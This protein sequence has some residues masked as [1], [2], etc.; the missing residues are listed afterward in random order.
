MST[1]R[2][3]PL[4]GLVFVD[5]ASTGNLTLSGL[6]TVDSVVLTAGML[7]LARL[8]SSNVQAIYRVKSGAW[9]VVDPGIGFGLQVCVR[10]GSQVGSIFRCVTPDPIVWGTTV[11]SFVTAAGTGSAFNP[12][13]PGPI[14][15]DTPSTGAFSGL[16]SPSLTCPVGSFPLAISGSPTDSA[17]AT[18][19][20]LVSNT[21]LTTPGAA[22]LELSNHNGIGLVGNW[23][24]GAVSGGQSDALCDGVILTA[25]GAIGDGDVV[26]YTG[27]KNT[28]AKA[29]ASGNLLTI[30]GVAVG[31][32]SGGKVRV[33]KRGL[34]YVNAVAG[35]TGATLLV[36]S[37]TAGAV[38][39]GAAAIGALIGRSL[40]SVDATV[41][42]KLLC[43]LILG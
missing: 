38:A 16:T 17:G 9:D 19:A 26:V 23:F 12:T 15:G 39:T 14:G 3:E 35:T 31:A 11:T 25:S 37:S 24:Y 43:D 13:T 20:E 41:A 1:I 29:A 40:E 6:Q 4:N 21:T 27:T 2:V 28:V 36:T 22:L 30:A 5:A 33:A 34:V 32:A 18:V 10:G 8:Q 42:G 7:C